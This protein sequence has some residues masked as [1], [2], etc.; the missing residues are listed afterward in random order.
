MLAKIIYGHTQFSCGRPRYPVPVPVQ[1]QPDLL[2]PSTLTFLS[3]A[4]RTRTQFT[5]RGQC[6]ADE[7]DSG[8]RSRRKCHRNVFVLLRPRSL[9]PPLHQQSHHRT[10]RNVPH[11]PVSTRSNR[12]TYKVGALKT[13]CQISLQPYGHAMDCA[14]DL[15]CP[16]SIV[17]HLFPHVDSFPPYT[18]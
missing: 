9:S 17:L 11:P 1:S 5:G 3:K 15:V 12:V 14:R 4:Q 7:D 8:W 13:L 6:E 10:T 18:S 16:N 2:S